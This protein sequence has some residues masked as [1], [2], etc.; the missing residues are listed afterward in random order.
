MARHNTGR[1]S[2]FLS[3]LVIALIYFAVAS[4]WIWYS[5]QALNDLFD[6]PTLISSLQTY[7]GIFYVVL[8]SL[9]LYALM[10]LYAGRIHQKEERLK[11]IEKVWA[12]DRKL[13]DVLFERIPVLIT[14]YDPKLEEFEVNR[15]FEKVVGWSNEEVQEINL[16]EECLPDLEEREELVEFMSEPGLGWRE[17]TLTTREGEKIEVSWTNI[18]LT[19]EVS[20]GIGVDMTEIKAKETELRE[21]ERLLS[22]MFNSLEE[23]V[24]LVDPDDR[25]IIDCNAATER[26]FGYEKEELIGKSTKMLHVDDKAY[27]TFSELGKEALDEKGFFDTEFRMKK[28]NGE[29][30]HSEHTVTLVYDDGKDTEVRKVVS[31][32][33]DISERKAYE[34]ELKEQQ[35]RLLRSQQIG[36]IG[37]W[38]FDVESEEIIWSPVM[39]DIFERDPEQGPPSYQEIQQDYYGEDSQ[40]HNDAVDSAIKEG[41]PYEL[42]LRLEVT[43]KLKYIRAIGLPVKN[44]EGEVIQLT[45]IV[46]DI[47]KRKKAEI[48]LRKSENRIEAITSNI[49]GVVFRYILH[50]DGSDEL[51]FV[52][53]GAE[54]VWG[55]DRQKAMEDN[56]KVWENILEEDILKVQQSIQKSAE[57]LERWQAEWRYRMP[58]GSVHWQQGIGIPHKQ[59]DGT[60]VWDSIIQDIT[61][62]KQL[63]NRVVQS[64]IKG[65][66]RERRRIAQELHDGIGQYL[67]ASSMNLESIKSEI[68]K[69]PEKQ[70]AR[71]QSGLTYLKRAL[72]ETRAVSHNLMP[73]LLD[74]YGLK[75]A[76]QTLLDNIKKA[77][78]ISI[79][80][81]LEVIQSELPEQIEKNIYRIIQEGISNA[82]QHSECNTIHVDLKQTDGHVT[83]RIED[84][85]KGADPQK[86]SDNQGMGLRSMKA[87][88]EA[89]AGAIYFDTKP[90][91]GMIVTVTVP[92]DETQ[93]A[94]WY[95]HY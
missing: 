35:R 14:I 34:K 26:L 60:I 58:D 71:F 6:D 85:G 84:D 51:S 89:M 88:T 38:Q 22:N 95:E 39:Y 87:R 36:K 91:E 10:K 5:D 31:V 68:E 57:D 74:D 48:A 73:G 42:D 69:L 27:Y 49:P 11:G 86:L 67:S 64:V 21:S 65:E 82:L 28:K 77:T 2:G 17:F 93:L 62:E 81:D 33:R 53:G 24:I 4:F 50:P 30:F 52:S 44:S 94:E 59:E 72:S 79:T 18:R 3:P 78:D 61:E 66:D 54:E 63:K 56:D 40:K 12:S 13:I 16:L 41:R 92:L 23:S 90:G 20:V 47:T 32:I 29:E 8:T 15:E 46:Q 9:G 75:V 43:N 83:C 7:K 25:T 80:Q 19:D 76:V 1:D 55:F 37:D 45:G 70:R